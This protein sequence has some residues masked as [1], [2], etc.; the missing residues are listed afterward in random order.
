MTV[1]LGP[2]L[3]RRDGDAFLDGRRI[4][5]TN[6]RA[7]AVLQRRNDFAARRVVLWIGGENQR[8]IQPQAHRVALNLHVAFLHDVEQSD[9][10]LAGEIRQA[11]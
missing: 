1:A 11:R 10:D 4:M 2:R 5:R 6:L 7:D 3:L 9:L 8:D